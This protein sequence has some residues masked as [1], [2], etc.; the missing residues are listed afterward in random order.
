MSCGCSKYAPVELERK[1]IR[2]RINESKLLKQRL[3]GI[4]EY[5]EEYNWHNLYRCAECDQLWQESCAWNVGARW[6]LFQVPHVS[7]EEWLKEP[8]VQPYDL[9]MYWAGYEEL[10]AQN[11]EPTDYLCREEGCEN[12]AIRWHILCK[13]HYWATQLKRPRGKIFPPYSIG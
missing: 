6:Y 2:K 7:V 1:S 4:A 10:M 12:H 8:Y 3:E 11:Y 13:E 9:M 5:R